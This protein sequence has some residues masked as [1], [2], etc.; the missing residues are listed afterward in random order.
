MQWVASLT[1]HCIVNPWQVSSIFIVLPNKSSDPDTG[2]QLISYH[3]ESWVLFCPFNKIPE[4]KPK[5]FKIV[6]PKHSL[7]A[8]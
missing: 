8:V 4:H 7:E 6:V 2:L 3:L 1:P 5:L